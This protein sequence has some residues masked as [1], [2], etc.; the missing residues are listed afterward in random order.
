MSSDGLQQIEQG[1]SLL[2]DTDLST[3]DHA[4]LRE[5]TAALVRVER[6]LAVVLNSAVAGLERTAPAPGVTKRW[7]VADLHLSSPAAGALVNASRDLAPRVNVS[8]GEVYPPVFPLVVEAQAAG[9]LSADHAREIVK[10][11][12]RIPED[13]GVHVGG[14]IEGV[15]VAAAVGA[16]PV[17]FRKHVDAVLAPY[18]REQIAEAHERRRF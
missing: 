17:G 9:L 8:T 13:L 2:L 5:L 16:D 1:I 10:A 14:E 18:C 4:Q 15:L 11:I 6:R 12:D 7:L 3:L